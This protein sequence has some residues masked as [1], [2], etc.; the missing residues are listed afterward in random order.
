MITGANGGIGL[1][2]A[3][4]LLDRGYRVAGLDVQ[5]DALEAVRE[6]TP[7]LLVQRCDV[8]AEDDVKQAVDAVIQA[9]GRIDVLVNNAAVAPYE[10]FEDMSL[11]SM[12][13]VFE[14]NVF[15]YVRTI[16]AVLPVMR[17]RR[18][19]TI[20]NVAS[21]LCFVGLPMLPAYGSSKGA[22]EG[23]TRSLALDLTMDG[24]AVKLFHPPS[25]RTQ[26][27]MALRLPDFLTGDPV[28]VGAAMAASVTSRR[29][30]VTADLR[31]ELL[32]LLARLT[33]G[34][35]GRLLT[36]LVRFCQGR[37]SGVDAGFPT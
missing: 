29:M 23:L 2:A 25:T 26:A 9:W 11:D 18:R 35:F 8:R 6:G 28:K 21:M 13:N 19:G 15:G 5:T 3:K 1:E 4:S 24:I 33:P 16:A 12:R 31:T 32:L 10:R 20:V 22:V 7:N 14:I 30:V 27:A 36:F 17:A 37:R 34:L